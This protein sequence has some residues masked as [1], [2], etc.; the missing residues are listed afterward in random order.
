[1]PS[2]IDLMGKI[3]ASSLVHGAELGCRREEVETAG[4]T[5]ARHTSITTFPELWRCSRT[6]EAHAS[7]TALY[8]PLSVG[9]DPPPP[10]ASRPRCFVMCKREPRDCSSYVALRH[11]R[12]MDLIKGAATVNAASLRHYG[13]KWSRTNRDSNWTQANCGWC[14]RRTESEPAGGSYTGT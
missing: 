5:S 7:S 11:P 2:Q 14:G 12:L 8:S 13:V 6:R 3:E 1:M 9:P 10:T 4:V